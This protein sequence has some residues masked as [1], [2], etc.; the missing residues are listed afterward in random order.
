M[1]VKEKLDSLDLLDFLSS[2]HSLTK[3]RTMKTI[4]IGQEYGLVREFISL[5]QPV[6]FVPHYGRC[7]LISS[8]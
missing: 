5:H 7:G 3:P 8:S 2:W 1:Q 4:K 6:T